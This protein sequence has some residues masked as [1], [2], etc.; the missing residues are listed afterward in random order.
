[1]HLLWV[2][3]LVCLF[4]LL[5]RAGEIHRVGQSPLRC[6]GAGSREWVCSVSYLG[7][8]WAVGSVLV[9]VTCCLPDLYSQQHVRL[10]IYV[11]GATL[12][13]FDAQA[14]SP[15]PQPS[16]PLFGGFEKPFHS[17]SQLAYL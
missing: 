2:P 10:E 6:W 11:E 7:Q 12:H 4:L 17:M 8:K 16:A 9:P 15:K 3:A 13:G 1:M 5:P 14:R